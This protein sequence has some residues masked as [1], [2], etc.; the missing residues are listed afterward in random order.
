MFK[1]KHMDKIVLFKVSRSL[2]IFGS[3]RLCTQYSVGF[4]DNVVRSLTISCD[5]SM[6]HMLCWFCLLISILYCDL[7]NS[8]CFG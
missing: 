1:A 8:H 3:Y 4:C 2:E 6:N 5:Y 7:Q